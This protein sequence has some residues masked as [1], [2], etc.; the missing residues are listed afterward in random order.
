MAKVSLFSA[1][2]CPFA[3]RTRLVLA[4]KKIPF[5]L[6]EVDLQN[7][8]AWF[9]AKVSAY[10]KV[11]ALEHDGTRVWE[12]AIIN[13]YLGEVFPTPPLLPSEP[14]RRAVARIWI[15]YANTRFVP[16]FGAL[17][18]ASDEHAQAAAKTAL[19]DV[20]QFIDREGIAKHSSTGPFFLGATPSLVDFAYF[21]WIARWPALAH[22]RGFALPESLSHLARWREA[23]AA[24]PSV[25]SYQDPDDYYIARYARYAT[26][27]NQAVA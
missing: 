11:P 3:H 4:E 15:D 23:V 7:K 13:E 18:R 20:L 17:L 25:V 1:R 6:K 16:A 12:S 14:G 9:D 24:L 27:Q 10:G 21:P 19:T 8:P 26:P 5:E 2:A 22:Y